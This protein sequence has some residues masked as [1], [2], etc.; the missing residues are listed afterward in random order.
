MRAA[1]NSLAVSSSRAAADSVHKTDYAQPQQRIAL[2]L[3]T[4]HEDAW[5]YDFFAVLRRLE[6]FSVPAP[7]WG[8]SPLPKAELVRIGQEPAL[9][10]A[11]AT[12]SAFEEA[13]SKSPPRLRQYFIGYIGANGPLPIHLS[14]F[15]RDRC[16][17]HGDRTWLGFL[18]GFTHRFALHFYRAWAQARPA[19]ALDRPAEDNFRSY[20]G[21][22]VG[23][24]TSAR[25]ERDQIHDDA[26]LFFSGWLARQVRSRDSVEAV[27]RAYFQVQAHLE[28]WMGRW[29]NLDPKDATRL[30]APLGA[31]MGQGAIMG[32]RV[33]DRQHSVRLHLGP[34][35]LERY[36][37]FLPTGTAFP[38]LCSWLKQLLGDEYEWD[39]RLVLRDKEVPTTQLGK[40]SQLG[41]TSWLGQQARTQHAA[42]VIL[43]PA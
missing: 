22:F 15:I 26:R 29:M 32:Q 2:Q 37:M 39:A 9:T 35:S 7:R 16:L 36:R 34:L 8:R 41:W 40:G 5:R 4:W 20:V 14:D 3:Q 30:G 17:N 18:D 24:G 19:V 28:P 10:F 25:K 38:V 12:F 13:T 23:A 11:P 43:R 33:W 31:R 27:I 1:A 21:A 42:D 6:S